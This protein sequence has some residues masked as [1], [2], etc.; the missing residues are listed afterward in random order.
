[1]KRQKAFDIIVNAMTTKEK[2]GETINIYKEDLPE[3][4]R[5]KLLDIQSAIR[6][7]TG[8]SFE[9]SYDIMSNALDEINEA[10]FDGL[11]NDYSDSEFA[12]I[13]TAV[14][15]SWLNINNQAEI[16]DLAHEFGSDIAAASAIWYDSAVKQ[17]IDEIVDYI[18]TF[19]E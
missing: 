15:L 19:E 1:M 17:A 6:D 11:D 13:Y 12:S 8:A 3:D 7:D 5:N 10:T 2:N 16:S 9:L 4:I 18:K 14:Q